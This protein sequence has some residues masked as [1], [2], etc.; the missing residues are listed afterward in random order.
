MIMNKMKIYQ[1]IIAA[2]VLLMMG[3]ATADAQESIT[4]A[5]TMQVVTE[6]QEA[7]RDNRHWFQLHTVARAY[8]DRIVVRWAPDEY[9]PWRYL[10]GYGYLVQRVTLNGENS[11]SDTIATNI[12]PWSRKQ[13][14]ER[15]A[16][17][18]SLA[19]A[20]VQTIFGQTTTLS[21]TQAAPGSAASVMEV[22]EEQQSIYSFAMLIAE[23]RPDLAEA[24][25]LSYT[26]RDVV[27]GALY[28]YIIRPLVP[29]SI[30]PVRPGI[31]ADVVNRPYQAPPF[32]THITDTIEPPAGIRLKWP[33]D[34]YTAFDIERRYDGG[35]W[36]KLNEH[37]YI[38]TIPETEAEDFPNQYL[39]GGLQPGRY[40]YR[41]RAYDTFGE[42]T[43]P[44]EV[45]SVDMPNLAAPGAPELVHIEILRDDDNIRAQLFW[46][47]KEVEPDVVGFLPLYYNEQL[48][49]GQ[50][51][52]LTSEITAPTDTTCI[53]TVK[54][55]ANGLIAIAAVDAAGNMGPSMPMPLRVGDLV[56]PQV[57]QNL[58]SLVSSTGVITLLW[59]P[60][61]DND[62]YSYEVWF[63]ND[64]SHMFSKISA[65]ELRDTMFVDTI[66]VNTNQRYVYYKVKA[67]DW[68]SNAS[69]FT[70]MLAVPVPDFTPPMP[71]RLD[72][73]QITNEKIRMW[74]IGSNEA[75]VK[76]HRV[77][78][79]LKGDRSWTLLRVIDEDS[80]SNHQ[81]YIED[82]PEYNQE[83][84][85]VYAVETI[86]MMGCSS[87]LSLLQSFWFRGPQFVDVE[88]LLFGE[89][90]EST[91]EN[92]LAWEVN[93]LPKASRQL[94]DGKSDHYYCVF[95][96]G[97][98]D[99][100]FE[101]LISVDGD[102]LSHADRL[103]SP[104]ET[105]EYYVKLRFNDG[106]EGL[107][108]SNIVKIVA[109]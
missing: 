103:S 16:E 10:N 21:Q 51:T 13:F 40:E 44:S 65:P 73:V 102:T 91:H 6:Q 24:M 50:W 11:R 48:F 31:A 14:M 62:L 98:N 59:N 7:E 78:R 55:L 49:G 94:V 42:L 109:K 68:S 57:P 53:V 60:V 85:Y 66:D 82:A 38:S 35:A 58:R 87:G 89:Y 39:D 18:D 1:N 61:P 90:N 101:F 88:L 37:P 69:E 47:K 52:P 23:R 70:P 26:D 108:P 67:V 45:V 46:R 20:A 8:G 92:R 41:L 100:D 96:K 79:Q 2:A 95:R 29:D 104:G 30:L 36:V 12:H 71:C 75:D 64:P 22:Y 81:F 15:F 27:P 5:D 4:S 25:G 32:V 76:Y 84:R 17:N 56:P 83:K 105:A 19:G 9:V 33:R 74:W 28:D 54:G 86:D 43:A 99:E 80:I 107:E 72:S 34:N 97:F 63:A 77:F 93:G 3:T 106:R